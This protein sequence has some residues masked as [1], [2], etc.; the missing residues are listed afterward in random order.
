[1]PTRYAIFETDPQLNTDTDW[2]MSHKKGFK[3]S[4]ILWGMPADASILEIWSKLADV[5]LV[6]FA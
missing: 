3:G 2:A 6:G 1:M 4:I 5:G